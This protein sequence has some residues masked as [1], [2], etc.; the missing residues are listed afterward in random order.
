MR[1]KKKLF[2]NIWLRKLLKIHSVLTILFLG[3]YLVLAFLDPGL[4]SYDLRQKYQA[5]ADEAVTVTATV[6]DSPAKPVVSA[7]AQ[8]DSNTG[9]LSV[10]LAWADDTNTYTYD[11]DR[12]SAPLITGL[13]TSGY[14]DLNVVVGTTYEYI[15]T[16]HG[17]M[18]PGVATSDPVMVTTP[19]ECVIVAATPTVIISS[20]GGKAVTGYDGVPRVHNRRPIFSGTTNMVNATMQVVIGPTDSL[21]ATFSANT[22][23]YW[24]WKPPVGLS[25]GTQVFT[26]TAIDPNDTARQASASLTFR[27]KQKDDKKEDAN[28]TSKATPPSRGVIEQF[29]QQPPIDFSLS[30]EKQDKTVWRGEALHLLLFTKYLSQQYDNAKVPLRFSIINEEGNVVVSFTDEELLNRERQI[31]KQL[32]IPSY[33]VAG[34]YSVQV[35]FLFDPVNVSQVEHFLLLESPLIQLGGGLVITYPEVIRY[36]GWITFTLL[37]LLLLWLLLFMREYGMYL[38]AVRHITERH[39]RKAGFL[40]KRKGAIG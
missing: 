31:R 34:K 21:I 8:C 16:A 25:S 20:F 1:S 10:A 11:I 35:E 13:V 30:V 24:E 39:L 4:L 27:I 28:T 19:A 12:D 26:V 5:L 22:N 37:G 9:T 23:G 32:S 40:T 3:T 36:L 29:Q 38:Q 15:V 6:L 18:G 33:V 17:P 7:T 2:R 14:T